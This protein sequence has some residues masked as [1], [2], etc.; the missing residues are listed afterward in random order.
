MLTQQGPNLVSWALAP[1]D[2]AVP[3]EI[4]ENL[5]LLI[6]DLRDEAKKHPTASAG[7]YDA[8]DRFC[9]AL[10]A[11]LDERERQRVRA[12]YTELQAE[13]NHGAV[14]S[15][16][17]EA[18]RNHQMSWPQFRREQAQ[19]AELASEAQ[20]KVRAEQQRPKLE[21]EARAVQIRQSLDAVYGRFRE[22]MREAPVR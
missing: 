12:G 18:R 15:Q 6:E 22:A 19:R 9:S 8:G 11:V 4:R 5:T 16:A 10:I 20:S 1:L 21:W 17:L 2:E 3:R 13:I 7:A 14:T